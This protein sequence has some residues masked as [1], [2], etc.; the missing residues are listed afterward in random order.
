MEKNLEE[1]LQEIKSIKEWGE[2]KLGLPQF[3]NFKYYDENFK[4]GH[5]VYYCSSL[6]IPKNYV[7]MYCEKLKTEKES[8]ELKKELEFLGHEVYY[9][10]YEATASMRKISKSLLE[11]DIY[12]KVYVIFHENMHDN[13]KLAEFQNNLLSL[14]EA[15]ADI[16]GRFGALEYI[17]EK[18]GRESKEYKEAFRKVEKSFKYS[19]LI[20]KYF[21]KIEQLLNSNIPEKEKLVKK[22]ILLK[23]LAKERYDTCGCELKEISIAE[24]AT[25][26]T[27]SRFSPLTR[28]V[29][30][31]AGSTKKAIIIFKELP[32]LINEIKLKDSASA[33]NF[34]VEFLKNY[35]IDSV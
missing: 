15:C 1:K 22:K 10:T 29:Y 4:K 27:Y 30:K 26:M 33:E 16:A 18:Y 3:N 5:I 21:D 32:D 9:R 28:E 24:L 31:K 8:L 13:L 7:N 12:R 34:C 19:K 17:E 23:D 2:K 6:K 14:E 25:R 35:L 11:S 20:I